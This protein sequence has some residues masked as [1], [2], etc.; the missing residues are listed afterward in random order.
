MFS[1]RIS[2]RAVVASAI[3]GVA[4]FLVPFASAL[5]DGGGTFFPH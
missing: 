1:S 5:A 2:F 4:L 3:L